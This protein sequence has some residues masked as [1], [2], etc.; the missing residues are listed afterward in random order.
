MIFP[1]K[2][3][4]GLSITFNQTSLRGHLRNWENVN[5]T[6]LPSKTTRLAVIMRKQVFP[7][8]FLDLKYT[9]KLTVQTG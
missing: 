1:K 3:T 8:L 2:H 9:R 6:N 7:H 4:L 5:L